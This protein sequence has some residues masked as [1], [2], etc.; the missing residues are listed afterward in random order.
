MRT[1]SE[2]DELYLELMKWIFEVNWKK[3]KDGEV[4]DADT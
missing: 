2:W 4:Q 1:E 3:R